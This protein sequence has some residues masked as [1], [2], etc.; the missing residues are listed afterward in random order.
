[1]QY[2]LSKESLSVKEYSKNS[3][4]FALNW[5]KTANSDELSY[6]TAKLPGRQ[7]KPAR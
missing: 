2:Q 4:T 5:L 3:S 1:M 6:T 7:L